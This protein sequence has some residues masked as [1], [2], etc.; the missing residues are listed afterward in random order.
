LEISI[1][2]FSEY[3]A[4]LVFKYVG[5]L[6]GAAQPIQEPAGGACSSLGPA[7]QVGDH[8]W[9]PVLSRLS[10]AEKPV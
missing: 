10:S 8:K 7:H 3:F 5:E 4:I 9:L 6:E 2:S 1:N